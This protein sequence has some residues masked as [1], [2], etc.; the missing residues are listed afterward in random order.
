MLQAPAHDSTAATAAQAPRPFV[1]FSKFATEDLPT[2]HVPMRVINRPIPSILDEEKV[3]RFMD[4]IRVSTHAPARPRQDAAA[5]A[6]SLTNFAVPE[7]R[8]L[9]AHRGP[10]VHGAG[11]P[12][13]L[14][15]FRRLSSV[16]SLPTCFFFPQI[17]HELRSADVLPPC[18]P[19]DPGINA[20]Q[21]RGPQAVT[22]R[23]DSIA[24]HRG[25]A[26]RSA[27]V[28]RRVLSVLNSTR[29][30]SHPVPCRQLMHHRTPAEKASRPSHCSI[31]IIVTFLAQVSVRKTGSFQGLAAPEEEPA[32]SQVPGTHVANE[33][34]QI[35]GAPTL[36]RR[37]ARPGR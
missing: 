33:Q 19:H 22:E 27:D 2:V 29:V 1:N 14:L 17:R 21:L 37:P 23:D 16:R 10:Q 28:P 30:S 15:C 35:S 3:L 32:G 25:P 26:V 7:R 4:D 6:C 18:A 24:D 9:Y 12:A 8:R 13:V 11:R 20:R 31:C 34:G 36:S 5:E